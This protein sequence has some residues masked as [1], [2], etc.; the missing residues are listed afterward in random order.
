MIRLFAGLALPNGRRQQI[1]LIQNGLKN[2]RWVAPENLHVTLRFIG[3]VDENV[4]EEVSRALDDVRAEPFTLTIRGLGTFGRPP[5]SVWAGVG[6]TPN[7]ALAH[8]QANVESILV[9]AGLPPEGRKY[10]PHVT[11]ARLRKSPGAQRL[12][13]YMESHGALE[14]PAF[15]VAGFTLFESRLSHKGAQYSAIAEYEF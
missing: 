6:D 12:S 9:R 5:S 15:D 3:E 8:L 14:L 7:G 4:V 1:S 10:T 2:A 11:L 13:D